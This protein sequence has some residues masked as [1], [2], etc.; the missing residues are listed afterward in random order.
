VGSLC[1]SFGKIGTSSFWNLILGGLEALEIKRHLGTLEKMV[2]KGM[3][4]IRED[5]IQ[6]QWMALVNPLMNFRFS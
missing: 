1:L 6:G 2:R 5:C 3:G 4:H